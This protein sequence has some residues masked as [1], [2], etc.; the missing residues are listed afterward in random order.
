[1]ANKPQGAG[2]RE[3]ALTKGR[4]IRPPFLLRLWTGVTLLW[5]LTGWLRWVG[6]LQ[7]RYLIETL[8]SAAIFRYLVVSGLITGVAIWPVL[9]GLIRSAAWAK[10]A[11]G[12]VS[13][14]YLG[15]Y[16]VERLFL[17]RSTASQSN[18][19]FVLLLSVLYGGL[20]AWILYSRRSQVYLNREKRSHDSYRER[21]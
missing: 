7:D 5:S 8:T 13:V 21:T 2:E 18:T 12:V 16:W 6:A 20:V 1:M 3:S 10:I 17:W 15:I 11:V 14:F 9:V 4:G 19:P